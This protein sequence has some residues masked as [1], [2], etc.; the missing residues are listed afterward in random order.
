MGQLCAINGSGR[1]WR[2]HLAVRGYFGVT[3]SP[4]VIP[5]DCRAVT[6]GAI[7]GFYV[8]Q[9]GQCPNPCTCDSC[10]EKQATEIALWL[11]RS[12]RKTR[13]TKRRAAER[14]RANR[15]TCAVE[16]LHFLG[17]RKVARGAS[18]SPSNNHRR[19]PHLIRHPTACIFRGCL[20]PNIT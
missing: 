7:L 15:R 12:W 3:T 19:L 16:S 8:S 2:S 6:N 13:L 4:I 18:H 5:G 17:Y 9:F 11:D 14:Q 1:P 10:A 20:F